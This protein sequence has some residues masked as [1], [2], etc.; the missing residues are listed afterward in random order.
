MALAWVNFLK[1]LLDVLHFDYK[2]VA[3]VRI[4]VASRPHTAESVARLV[5]SAAE[6]ADDYV[7]RRGGIEP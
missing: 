2:H 5:R 1:Q 7:R 6:C 4:V 3:A